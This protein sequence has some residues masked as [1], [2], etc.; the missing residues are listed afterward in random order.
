MMVGT[1]QNKEWSRVGADADFTLT[2]LHSFVWTLM[3]ADMAICMQDMS[4]I[5]KSDGKPC[6]CKDFPADPPDKDIL[7]C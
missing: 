7:Q 4:K 2:T 5:N 6:S 3:H 1:L